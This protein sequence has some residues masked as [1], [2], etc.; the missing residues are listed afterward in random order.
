MVDT[1]KSNA[2]KHPGML[3]VDARQ[4]RRT[5]KQ[6][7]E[8]KAHTKAV[9]T[10]AK[11]QASAERRAIITQVADIMDSVERDEEAILAHTNRPDLRNPS[12]SKH[13]AATQK[14]TD[15]E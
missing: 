13:P 11:D 4:Q 6:M 2:T 7:E 3:V 5:R 12:Q 8:D 14:I 10:A 9:A 1:C 15:L